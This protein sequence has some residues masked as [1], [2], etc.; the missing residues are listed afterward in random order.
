MASRLH[1]C[2]R[3]WNDRGVWRTLKVAVSVGAA[4]AALT[5]AATAQPSEALTVTAADCPDLHEVEITRLLEIE[6]GPALSAR[7]APLEISFRCDG[8]RVTIVATDPITDKRL[9]RTVDL[10]PHALQPDRVVA[11]LASQLF[12]ASWSELLLERPHDVEIPTPARPVP[13]E[14]QQLAE[15]TT[16]RALAP[17][18]LAGRGWEASVVAG[19]RVR[20]VTT[21]LLTGR[22]AARTA[23]AL[24]PL[25]LFL[26]LGGERGAASRAVGVVDVAL[27]QALAGAT[28]RAVHRGAWTLDL[29]ASAGPAWVNLW[30]TRSAAGY[31]TS[32]VSGVVGEGALG[33]AP[34][35]VLGLV[36]LALL[37]QGGA[38]FSRARGYVAGDRDVS[39][40]GPWLGAGVIL[41]LGEGGK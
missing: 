20:Q 23:V 34:G 39:L 17:T 2:G 7:T 3:F 33:I 6:L 14:A 19:P 37:L 29:E 26:E 28:F 11:I 31:Q 30:G 12:L 22:I 32:S 15:Q 21:P 18:F 24:G 9:D 5:S 16:R 8:P 25:R 41:G 35:L 36:R 10:G 40:A 38:N 1:G 4:L 27:L 13:P